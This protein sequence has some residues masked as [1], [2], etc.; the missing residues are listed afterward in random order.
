MRTLWW[1]HR[2]KAEAVDSCPKGVFTLV[3]FRNR[4]KEW[5]R[6]LLGFRFLL[7]Y[8][9]LKP[10]SVYTSGFSEPNVI[11]LGLNHVTDSRHV[12]EYAEILSRPDREL[13]PTS[14]SLLFHFQA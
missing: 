4:N 1:R 3:G 8:F 11:A 13:S 9:P 12:I 14:K 2:T 7:S 6:A 10:L 5:R